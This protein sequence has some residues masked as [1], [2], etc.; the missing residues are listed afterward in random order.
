MQKFLRSALLAAL[1]A[2]V[3]PAAQAATY[4][5]SGMMDSGSLIGESLSGSLSF[6]GDDAKFFL[7]REEQG[8]SMVIITT[9]FRITHLTNKSDV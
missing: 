1:L 5:F 2:G 8:G 9:K 4:S 3:L 7:L 6:D